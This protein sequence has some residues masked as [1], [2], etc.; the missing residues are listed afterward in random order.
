MLWRKNDNV[1][2][3]T[4]EHN[5]Y[6]GKLRN[7][8]TSPKSSKGDTFWPESRIKK[9]SHIYPYTMRRVW[10]FY[11]ASISRVCQTRKN[12]AQQ[13]EGG[14]VTDFRSLDMPIVTSFT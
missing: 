4:E 14:N 10:E 8:P 2:M 9:E 1:K 13:R 11:A 5:E 12:S 7:G 6:E 3:T